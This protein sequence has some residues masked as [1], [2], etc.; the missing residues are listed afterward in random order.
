LRYSD[1]SSGASSGCG[2]IAPEMT[3]THLVYSNCGGSDTA[4][5]IVAIIGAIVTMVVA[6]ATFS[7]A[8]ATSKLGKLDEQRRGREVRGIA[9]LISRELALLEATIEDALR[10]KSWAFYWASPGAAWDQGGRVIVAELAGHKADKLIDV[11]G[12]L[13]KWARVARREGEASRLEGSIGFGLRDADLEF[14]RG[15]LPKL[16]ESRQFLEPL[17]SGLTPVP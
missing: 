3:T 10:D 12:E 1:A 15:L 2:S 11:V 7:T 6:F 17:A 13:E 5:L 4:A 9:R 16:R 14:L 8:S